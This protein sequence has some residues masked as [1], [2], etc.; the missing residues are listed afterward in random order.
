MVENT[1]NCK[2]SLESFAC[3]G[4]RGSPET[5]TRHRTRA[6]LRDSYQ[7]TY[8]NIK[9]P[10]RWTGK[11]TCLY[12][13]FTRHQFARCWN[14]RTT[15]YADILNVCLAALAAFVNQQLGARKDLSQSCA[16]GSDPEMRSCEPAA[17]K[18]SSN[19]V[20]WGRQEHLPNPFCTAAGFR[21]PAEASKLPLQILVV[22]HLARAYPS[23]RACGCGCAATGFCGLSCAVHPPG[24]AS[25]GLTAATSDGANWKFVLD[26][27][28]TTSPNISAFGIRSFGF[29]SPIAFDMMDLIHVHDS[30]TCRV[31]VGDLRPLSTSQKKTLESC[32]SQ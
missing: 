19:T 12:F 7:K 17:C 15:C 6:C 9:T 28:T 1:F 8:H 22:L 26:M 31:D 32:G 11:W 23:A 3:R 5:G 25:G 16:S 21:L 20:L 24:L 10:K 2:S 18:L 13:A 4:S 14:V 29:S 30:L 27:Q